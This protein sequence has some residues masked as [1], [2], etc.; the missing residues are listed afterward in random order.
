M[1]RTPSTQEL[2]D[3]VTTIGGE[4][5]VRSILASFYQKMSQDILVGFFFDGKDL[6]HIAKQQGDFILNAAG[7]IPAFQGKGPASAHLN[8]PPILTGHFDRR[9]VLLK[10]TFQEH[11]VPE[12]AQATWLRFEESFREMVVKA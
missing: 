2:H 10:E 9:L 8:M 1:R 11:Q 7:V 3:L 5:S 4:E 6:D 12:S